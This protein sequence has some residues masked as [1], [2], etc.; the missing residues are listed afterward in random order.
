MT[1][2]ILVEVFMVLL[3]PSR[4]TLGYYLS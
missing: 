2:V 1:P 4:R 3:S